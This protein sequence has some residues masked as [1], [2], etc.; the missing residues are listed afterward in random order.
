MTYFHLNVID[1]TDFAT[2]ITNCQKYNSSGK[3]LKCSGNN[4]LNAAQDACVSA[5]DTASNTIELATADSGD[6]TVLTGK[7][8]KANTAS[9]THVM[10]TAY[11][12]F[13]D[14]QN[15]IKCN[16]NSLTIADM[17]L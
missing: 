7:R 16:S 12:I 6:Y 4:F 2:Q 3:C 17:T 8:C 9:T 11:S 14:T 1:S 10:T 5:C 13:G 15:N